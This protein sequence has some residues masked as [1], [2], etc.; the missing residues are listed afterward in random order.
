M[1]LWHFLHRMALQVYDLYAYV[2]LQKYNLCVACYEQHP[3]KIKKFGPHSEEGPSEERT[4]ASPTD[5]IKQCVQSLVH[6]CQCR[7]A[8]C[9]LPRC[10]KMRQALNH[11][12]GCKKKNNNSCLICKQLVTLC[13][14]HAKNCQVGG[15]ISPPH[16]YDPSL[17][18]DYRYIVP[19]LLKTMESE[20]KS[21]FAH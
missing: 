1:F 11:F 21:H 13:C 12:K 2:V 20:V 4:P 9:R 7:D 17:T 6:T 3:H 16:L 15:S 18:L 8:S 5:Q 14:Y 10:P 19:Y